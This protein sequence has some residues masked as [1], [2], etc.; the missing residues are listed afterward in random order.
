[1]KQSETRT[2]TSILEHPLYQQNLQLGGWSSPA[3]DLFEHVLVT[4]ATGSG[5][6]RSVFLPLVEMTLRHFGQDANHKAAV[7]LV[8]GKG[9]MVDM[10]KDCV[11]RAGRAEDL[12]IF[13]EGGNCW[14]PLFEC[15]AGD[16]ATVAEYLFAILEERGGMG[17]G[18]NDSFWYENAKRLLRAAVGI[19]KA[20]HGNNMGGLNGI[21]RS[22]QLICDIRTLDDSDEPDDS[23]L[24]KGSSAGKEITRQLEEAF[25]EGRIS[26]EERKS[27]LDYMEND[28]AR[29]PW[30][31]L[32]TIFNM[33]KNY[34]SQFAKPELQLLFS[35]QAGKKKIMPEDIIDRGLIVV[36]SLS[37]SIYGEVAR[38][39]RIAIKKLFCEKILQ[40]NSLYWH[41][42]SEPRRINQV[43]PVI[44]GCDEFHTTLESMGNMADAYFLDRCREFRCMCILATQG[45]SALQ[46]VIRESGMCNHLL[47]NC[48]TKFFFA[49]DCP[50]TSGYF[51]NLLGYEYRTDWS[52][53][54][55][56]SGAVPRFRLPNYT[57]QMP[58]A[59]SCAT[60]NVSREREPRMRS[61]EL[62]SLP[63]GSAIVIG[64]GRKLTR[65]HNPPVLYGSA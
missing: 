49:N 36:V 63:N 28:V 23:N 32:G 26:H 62:G 31:T 44:Y 39:F 45:V 27:I 64:K 14:V 42:D 13:G 2:P 11:N 20:M 19:A 30:R 1:M 47:N 3:K 61:E 37:P 29:L 4:G 17:Y 54:Y 21:A 9:D 51:E 41:G 56:R 34:L 12:Y 52:L 46:S 18:T 16:V 43:R 50:E 10:A 22:L 60:V 8:D 40:R 58:A 59:F 5:K 35:E 25:I 24:L 33:G 38:P 7:F 48:R 57:F 65:F 6:T 55:Q 15:F 53:Q